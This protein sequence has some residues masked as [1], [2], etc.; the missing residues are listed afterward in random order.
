MKLKVR[1]WPTVVFKLPGGERSAPQPI[2]NDRYFDMEGT[3]DEIKAEAQKRRCGLI[4]LLECC[5]ESQ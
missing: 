5:E 1:M 4:A 2:R 3:F